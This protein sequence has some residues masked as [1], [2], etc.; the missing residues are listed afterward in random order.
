[1]GAYFGQ[2]KLL[3]IGI[4]NGIGLDTSDADITPAD[5][6]NG[7]IGYANGKK[8]I[9]TGKCF[10]FANYGT[11]TFD[12]IFDEHGNDRY[13]IMMKIPSITNTLF[14]SSIPNSD[15]VVQ[16][17]FNITEIEENK[18]VKVGTNFTTN[19]DIFVFHSQGYIFI[20]CDDI[21]NTKSELNYF[22]GKDVYV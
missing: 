16:E 7:K 12:L 13:G 11:A 18:A 4:T 8:V 22:I 17:V 9:G 1:M 15:I 21:Q 20:Y 3:R 19:G 6:Q 2:N 14:I 10:E 5:M